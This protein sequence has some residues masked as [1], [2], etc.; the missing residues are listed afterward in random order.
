MDPG[1][2]RQRGDGAAT[3]V[4]APLALCR[5]IYAHLRAL[6]ADGDT[7]PGSAVDE[8]IRA[9][10]A[11]LE[12]LVPSPEERRHALE[13]RFAEL[14]LA[15]E[16]VRNLRIAHDRAAALAAEKEQEITVAREAIVARDSQKGAGSHRGARGDRGP[17]PPAEDSGRTLAER[18]AACATL[19]AELELAQ[20]T[21][22]NLRIAH[23]RAAALAAEK[24]QE[25]TVAREA[26]VARDQQL[27]ESARTLAERTAACATLGAELQ[28][29][30][31]TAR[32]LRVAHD[33]AAAGGG[34]GTES[35]RRWPSAPPPTWRWTN[36]SAAA[37]RN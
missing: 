16:T 8:A 32:D 23:D 15:Q 29:A 9:G 4:A 11:A 27:Q 37:M 30:Q 12:L 26:I 17:G 19:D 20:E 34:E 1:L 21:V 31:A 3:A 24:E 14:E 6:L 13:V 28:L 5:S 2:R 7:P 35:A 10:R 33:R 25:I 18:T 22:R 36:S